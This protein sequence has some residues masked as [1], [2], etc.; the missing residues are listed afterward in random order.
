MVE[1]RGKRQPRGWDEL[2]CMFLIIF[3]FTLQVHDAV[4]DAGGEQVFGRTSR[5]FI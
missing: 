1:V 3:G 5:F 4:L 2:H